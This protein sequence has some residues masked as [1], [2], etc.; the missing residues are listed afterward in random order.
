MTSETE[1]KINEYL[2]DETKLY[3]DW[4]LG[5]T[6]AG[7]TQYTKEVGVIPKLSEL[8]QLCNKWIQQQTP[9]F[10]EKLCEFYCQ[11]RQFSQKQ[12][13]LLIAGVADVLTVVFAGV[14]INFTAVA[15]ILVTKNHLDNLC[16][17][18]GESVG[19]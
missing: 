1:I 11:N 5:L 14:P 2:A 10:Q 12:E 6:G 18:S 8:K 4:Y 19:K 13:T 15:V 9:V 16:H 3:Q 7:E 17:C